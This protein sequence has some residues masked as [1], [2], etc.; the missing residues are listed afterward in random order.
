MTVEEYMELPYKIEV[1]WH[2]TYW[3]A[4]VPDLPGCMTD[5]RS[6]EKLGDMILDVMKVWIEEV[7]D[8]G[9]IVPVPV[10]ESP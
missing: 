6:W 2:E 4:T 8:S 3:F 5:A 1:S 7:L 9:G 10:E